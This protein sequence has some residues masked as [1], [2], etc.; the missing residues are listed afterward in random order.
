MKQLLP[1][2]YVYRDEV[3][4]ILIVGVAFN[5]AGTLLVAMAKAPYVGQTAWYF[6]FAL[7]FQDTTGTAFTA[8]ALGPWWGA[9]V[10]VIS[11][12]LNSF[13]PVDFS[14]SFTL[15][16]VVNSEIFADAFVYTTVNIGLGLAW[17]YVGRAVHAEAVL[18]A[19]D[20]RV[21]GRRA[22]LS[23]L[24]LMAAGVV[25]ATVLADLVKLSL[26]EKAG[27]DLF[28]GPNSTLYWAIERHLQFLGMRAGTRELALGIFDFYAN[29]AD[30]GL[31]LLIALTLLNVMGIVPSAYSHGNRT[32]PVSLGQRLKVGA[33]S[34]VGFVA[35]YA[36]YLLLGRMVLQHVHFTHSPIGAG[37]ENWMKPIG[38]LLLFPFAVAYLV[39]VF[40]TLTLRRETDA[41]IEMRRVQRAELYDRIRP[42]NPWSRSG[43]ERSQFFFIQQNSGYGVLA[44]LVTWP[45]KS[46][47][48]NATWISFF[49]MAGVSLLFLFERRQALGAFRK[50]QEW[51]LRL[52]KFVFGAGPQASPVLPLL[53]EIVDDLKGGPGG[54]RRAGRISYQIAINAAKTGWLYEIRSFRGIDHLILIAP[55]ETESVGAIW[56][57]AMRMQE[58]TGIAAALVVVRALNEQQTRQLHAMCRNSRFVLLVLEFADMQALIEARAQNKDLGAVLAPTRVESRF[59]RM[60]ETG[61]SGLPR[62]LARAEGGV[63]GRPHERDARGASESGDAGISEA[64]GRIEQAKTAAASGQAAAAPGQGEPTG[65]G[66]PEQAIATSEISGRPYP[67]EQQLRSAVSGKTGHRQEFLICEETG[68]PLL[69]SEAARCEQTGRLVMPGVLEQCAITGKSVLPSELERCAVT[70]KRALRKLFVTSSVSGALILEEAAVQSIAGKFC[71]PLEARSCVW[72]GRKTHPD[73][74]RQCAL[75]GVAV[76]VEFTTEGAN[77]RLQPLAELLDGIARTTVGRE[78]WGIIATKTGVALRRRTRVETAIGSPDGRHLAVC[79]EVHALGLRARRAGLLFS[80][81][82]QSIVGRIASGKRTP[83]GW[84]AAR[85]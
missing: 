72:S 15:A 55:E 41:Q 25:S 78:L 67:V 63:P 1:R 43:L 79:V 9:L 32:I 13:W 36:A 29:I 75:T 24:A 49:A 20:V 50:A 12:T 69:P 76:H 83:K 84:V 64:S 62:W 73:D 51:L 71:A 33:D 11:S 58:E 81:P 6:S 2:E 23:I 19:P 59:V 5:L 85:R 60:L 37:L 17:G 82:E 46:Y 45:A 10:G 16:S 30:K 34:V 35:V 40:G 66:M 3:W 18:I 70:G 61:A 42:P 57:F 8:L 28:Q 56:N 80:I 39:F 68:Q 53:L 74:L 77:P 22:L 52:N 21:F 27:G 47:L 48:P 14:G 26:L 44:S 7:L 65:S 4:P 54:L 31:S 38:A